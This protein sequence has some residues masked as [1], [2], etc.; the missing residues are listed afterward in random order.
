M[1]GD[2]RTVIQGRAVNGLQVLSESFPVFP[3]VALGVIF[4]QGSRDESAA[5]Q[6]LTHL[7][8]HMLFKGTARK[9]AAEISRTIEAI[10]GM[11]NGFTHKEATGIYVRFLSEHFD[12]VSG[13]VLEMLNEPQFAPQELA[14]ER[15]VVAEEIKSAREDP[16]DEAVDLL[17]RAFYGDHPLGFPVSG[18]V[19]TIAQVSAARLHDY[20]NRNYV[21]DRTLVAA[22]GDVDHARLE[23]RFGNGLFPGPAHMG[24][25]LRGVSPFT[26]CGMGNAERRTKP[27]RIAPNLK[28]RERR[29]ISQVFVGIGKPTIAFPDPRRCA[30]AVMNAA[31]G[32]ATSSRLFRRL[33]EDEGLVY[34]ISSFAELF[35]DTGVFGVFL[36]TDKKK[37][38]KT[39]KVLEQEWNRL[40][41]DN[42][43][44][45]EFETS[46]N[47][48]KGAMILSLESF[49]TRMMRLAQSQLMLNRVVTVE[50]KIRALNALTR[51]DMAALLQEL[52]RFEDYYAGAVGPVKE[53]ELKNL[54]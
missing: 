41:S 9:S 24:T 51:D 28:V 17:F 52:G 42:F 38:G 45:E 25:P 32:A 20:Y 21:R 43:T 19:D 53:A 7:T 27:V 16:E 48:T 11:I 35:T 40:V 8:E 39:L 34:S 10:G 23:A 12:L 49:S 30:L 22:V 2:L 37:L 33:R 44:P 13:L 18:E 46:R 4:N 15:E 3:S 29:E 50:E 47:Y 14:K 6:G 1:T 31:F 54:P 36:A 5:E 26:E